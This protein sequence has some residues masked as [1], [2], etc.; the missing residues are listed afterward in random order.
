MDA[1]EQP[2]ILEELRSGDPARES[3]ALRTLM[4]LLLSHAAGELGA[5]RRFVNAQDESVI[6]SAVARELGAGREAYAKF[7]NDAHLYGRLHLAVTHAIR[8]RLRRKGAKVSLDAGEAAA[9]PEPAAPEAGPRTVIAQR[10]ERRAGEEKNEGSRARLLG[11]TPE[12]D[13]ELVRLVVFEG[14]RSEEAGREL[15]VSADVVRQRM[16]R[17][18]RRLRESLL[19]PVLASLAEA[20][21][22]IFEA[23]LVER[24]DL[25]VLTDTD[26]DARGHAAGFLA[27]RM[28]ELLATDAVAVLGDQG[29]V[30]LLR[31][32]GKAKRG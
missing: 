17:L 11:A 22:E 21:R 12:A 7:E 19:G 13:R 8:S 2:R 4:N 25:E 20:D 29:V 14:R 15:G 3:A 30:Y 9:P 32:L 1:S 23:L 27:H 24:V 10:D 18:R 16:S 5:R 6:A 31:L 26:K 28:Q